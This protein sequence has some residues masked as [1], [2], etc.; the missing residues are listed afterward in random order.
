MRFIHTSDWHLGRIFFGEHLT[1]D[2]SY[3]LNNF[4]DLVD[5][6][7]PEAVLISGDIYDRA[8]PPVDAVELLDEI[9]CRLTVDRRVPV[10]MIAGN[11]DSPERVG[12]GNRLLAKQ[13]LHVIGPLAQP[14]SAVVLNDEFG[15]VHFIPITYAEPSVVRITCGIE[16]MLNHEQAMQLLVRQATRTIPC[17]RRMVAIAHAYIAGGEDSESER[18]LTVG[19]SGT[20]SSGVFQAFHYTALGHLH[21]AQR[22]GAENI[23]YC[24][25]LLK[26]SFSET[27]QKK[28]VCVVDMDGT[29]NS[30]VRFV[31][32]APRRDVRCI[33]GYMKDLLNVPASFDGQDDYIMVNLLD[34]QPVLDPMGRLRQVYP[35]IMGAARQSIT[36]TADLDGPTGD[37]RS[38]SEQELFQSFFAQVAGRTLSVE[39]NCLF[40]R[41]VED[42]FRE[43]QEAGTR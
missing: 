34:E 36:K 39:E 22:A 43:S 18:P 37:H 33:E 16:E 35:H 17:G 7:R 10:I 4:L 6:I 13:G 12:F 1:A 14:L 8:V 26:Y 27:D 15:P 24:G 42:V 3:V 30:A 41:I 32:L 2:Q 29:G 40:C 9:L 23:R 31:P 19:G 5:D 11:H 25:S 20:V 28:G 21:K 38:L